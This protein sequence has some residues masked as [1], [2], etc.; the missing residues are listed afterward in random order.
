M[1]K[2]YFAAF[3]LNNI[4]STCLVVCYTGKNIYP[5]ATAKI[6]SKGY[7]DGVVIDEDA[8]VE[9]IE[10]IKANILDTFKINIDEAILVLPNNSHKV[11]SGS[12]QSKI[13]T[14]MQVIHE[15]E[16]IGIRN[17][18]REATLAENEI[19][20]DETPTLYTLD[21]NRMLRTKPINKQS[22]T[23]KITSNIHTIPKDSLQ[24]FINCFARTNI[25]LIGCALNCDCATRALVSD[26]DLESNTICIDINQ[27]ATTI[28]LYSK[29]VLI[30]SN[31]VNFGIYHIIDNLAN[32]LNTSFYNAL[33][34]FEI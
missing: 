28:A 33:K 2:N 13:M 3:E 1:E 12:L 20:I 14:E 15:A 23:L 6:M 21:E 24:S 9:T 5:I 17:K 34:Y 26:L 31:K 4:Y 8:L 25:D 29:N 10:N 16:I 11:Y 22:S 27:D 7:K 18:L 30:K 32:S 19:L